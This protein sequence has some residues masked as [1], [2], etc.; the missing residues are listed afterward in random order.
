MKKT[1][2]LKQLPVGA[3][4]EV[5]GRKFTLLDKGSQICYCLS[6]EIVNTMPFMEEG[7]NVI[8][9]NDFR[10]SGIKVW[11]NREYLNDLYESGAKSTDII[12]F[13]L[14][15]KCTL[16]QREYGIDT[17]KVGLLTLEEYGEYYDII[18]L[19]EDNWWLAT[20]WRTPK[21]SLN[22]KT[23]ARTWSVDYCGEYCPENCY[24]YFGN[25]VRPTLTF[26][27]SLLVSF[28]TSEMEK[29]AENIWNEYINYLHEWAIDHQNINCA[30]SSLACYDEWLDNELD[31]D[32]D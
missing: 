16:G 14:D 24:S 21:Y 7:K 3:T 22:N 18:P 26:S 31:E 29:N 19:I 4:F 9:G 20:P 11:L 2:I 15:L 28:D 30:Y 10:D 27:S 12:P 6:T 13:K 5:W 23:T 1:A 32:R 8:C 25:G 17:V